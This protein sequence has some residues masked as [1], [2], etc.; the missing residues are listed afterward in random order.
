MTPEKR[1]AYLLSPAFTNSGYEV[2]ELAN[3]MTIV[4]PLLDEPSANELV[5]FFTKFIH[6]HQSKI[7]N[8]EL[9]ALI[10]FITAVKDRLEF[11]ELEANPERKSYLIESVNNSK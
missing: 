4:I 2:P 10:R 8:K 5:S 7:P 11:M 9:S 6:K 3:A 1:N